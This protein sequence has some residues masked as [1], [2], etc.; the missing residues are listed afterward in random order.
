M[1]LLLLFHWVYG[2][3]TTVSDDF[4]Q[5]IKFSFHFFVYFFAFS[6]SC[7]ANKKTAAFLEKK[8]QFCELFSQAVI[9]R[10]F[11]RH[12]QRYGRRWRM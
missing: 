5:K 2:Y 1:F 9:F 3:H 4:Q 12:R 10:I 6:S 8:Q 11:R 7:Q